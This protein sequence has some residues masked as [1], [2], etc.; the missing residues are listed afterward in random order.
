M[1]SEILILAGASKDFKFLEMTNLL[2]TSP[3]REES[4]EESD[5]EDE[6]E[7]E[8]GINAMNLSLSHV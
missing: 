2:Q 3:N 6:Y 1:S 4:D 8:S 5:I 7:G